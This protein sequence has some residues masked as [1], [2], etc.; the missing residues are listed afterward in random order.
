MYSNCGSEPFPYV[1]VEVDCT[2]GLV[3]E[4]FYGS[5]QVGISVIYSLM[6]AH[7]AA[8]QTLSNTFLKSTKRGKDFVCVACTSHRVF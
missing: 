4:A 5:D 6:V 7:K 1:V 3:V 8:C 2:G